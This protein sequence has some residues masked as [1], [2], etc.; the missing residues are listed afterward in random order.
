MWSQ[1]LWGFLTINVGWF[2]RIL[3]YKS[4]L[5]FREKSTRKYL[6]NKWEFPLLWISAFRNKHNNYII[7]AQSYPQ[8]VYFYRRSINFLIHLYYLEADVEE[9][10]QKLGKNM[11][12]VTAIW[13]IDTEKLTW[14]HIIKRKLK[15]I[16]FTEA[17]LW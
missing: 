12:D 11:F 10:I 9:H 15:Q 4:D 17:K 5:Y 3:L 6:N 13:S 16:N 8:W 7:F 14:H 2:R 1:L